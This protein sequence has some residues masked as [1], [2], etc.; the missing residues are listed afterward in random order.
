MKKKGKCF[1]H[2]NKSEFDSDKRERSMSLS[3]IPL[4]SEKKK[5]K[6]F[7]QRYSARIHVTNTTICHM[8]IKV[9][10]TEVSS[11]V[12]PRIISFAD[13]INNKI[14]LKSPTHPEFDCQ[15]IYFSDNMFVEFS[16]KRKCI[17]FADIV[18]Y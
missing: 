2:H 9:I 14:G 10:F 17:L 3:F 16:T 11:P 5:K 8:L 7:F 12:M 15:T 18:I 4:L 1:L 13:C 6:E